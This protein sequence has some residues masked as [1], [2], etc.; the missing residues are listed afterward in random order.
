LQRVWQSASARGADCAGKVV[1]PAAAAVVAVAAGGYFYFHRTPK[2][3]E[4]DTIVLADFTN[5]TGDPVFEGTLRQGL[6]VQLEQSPFLSIVPEQQVQQTLSLMGKPIDTKL[7][8]ELA[9]E[10]CQR[11][12]STA[13]LNGSIAQ[14]GTEYSLIL[15]AVNCSNGVS[16]TSVEARANDKSHVLDALGNAASDIR[17]KLGESLSTVQKFNA[18][19]EQATTPSLEAL[20]AYSLGLSILL[21]GN[22]AA[23]IPMFQRAIEIDPNFAMAHLSLGRGYANIGEFSLASESAK[24]S[25]ELRERVSERE[26]LEIESRYHGMVTH[27]IAK[28]RASLEVLV[29]LYPRDWAARNQLGSEYLATGQY[30][31]SL[32]EYRDALRLNP[33]NALAF[34]GIAVSFR[35]LNR[36]EEALDTVNEASAKNLDSARL[37]FER[38]NL[39]FLQ[40]DTA[41]MSQQAS[42]GKGKPGV[43]DWFLFSEALTAAYSGQLKKAREL[44]QSA[45]ISS[46]ATGE[47]EEAAYYEAETALTEALV[48]A[49]IL[50]GGLFGWYVHYDSALWNLR[51]RDAF[52]AEQVHRFN[53]YISPPRPAV[54]TVIFSILLTCGAC[55]VYELLAAG[56]AAIVNRHPSNPRQ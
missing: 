30:D 33:E 41:T 46:E 35:S 3:T 13:V 26:K 19:L 14:I 22:P 28:E 32:V 21:R 55:V 7:T 11:T 43:E 12:G 48:V 36:M 44:S 6:S 39:A 1:V 42:W 37:R 51:G 38:Y 52:I 15:K 29:Q 8:P 18:P 17:N 56:L 16:L 5:T 24:K 23:S 2:L 10:L 34:Y 50:L 31:K 27:D 40:H 49:A 45:V 47:K 53:T 54:F 25:F 20:Q 4:K 9:R